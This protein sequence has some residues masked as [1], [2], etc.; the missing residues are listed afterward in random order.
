RGVCGQQ[1]NCEHAFHVVGGA[2]HVVIENNLVTDFNA[3]VKINGRAGLFPDNGR[4]SNNTL[5]NRSPR[6]TETP[7][8][9]IDLVA[10]SNWSIEGNLIADFVKAGGDFTSYGAFAKG[11]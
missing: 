6:R 2:H 5:I 1:N 8:T 7:V 10:A 11:A 4:I 9:P 3:H